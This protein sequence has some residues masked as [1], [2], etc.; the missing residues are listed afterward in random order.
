MK[1]LYYSGLDYSRVKKQFDKTV[2]FL[3]NDDF[4]SAEVKKLSL[5]G[6][7][8]AKID[9][10]NR[11]LFKIA[12]FNNEKYIL[13][14]EVILNH[15]YKK[16][17]FLRGAEIDENKLPEV[18]KSET[19][20]VD[21][22]TS[23][24]FVNQH[25]TKFHLLDKAISFDSNQEEIFNLRP[26]LILIGSAGSGK[27]ALTLEKIK[28]LQGNILYITLSEYLQKNSF[29]LYYYD[30][31]RND[32]QEIDFL[33]YKEFLDTLYI[34][35]KKEMNFKVFDSWLQSRIHSFGFK[36]THKMFEEFRGVLTGMDVN[37]PYLNEAEYQNL[38]VKQAIFLPNE[39]KKVYE[40]FI[41]YLE[42]LEENKYYDINIASYNRLDLSKPYYDFLVIDEVQDFTN[43]QLFIVLKSLKEKGSFIICGDS[44]QIVHP[45]FFSWTKIKSLFYKHDLIGSE[46]KVLRTNYRNSVGITELANLLLKIKNARFGSIDKESTYLI[47]PI[48]GIKGEITLM[49]DNQKTR[50]ILNEKTSRSTKFAV[51]VLNEEEKNSVRNWF[52]TPLLFSIQ[53]AKGLEYE[54]VILYNF[55]SNNEKEYLEI[56]NGVVPNDLI[57]DSYLFSRSKDKSDKSL[58]AYKFYI[59]SLYVA[60]TRGIKNVFIL[61]KNQTHKIL[62]L[63]NLLESKEQVDI[64]VE[65][66]SIDDW[67]KEAYKLELQ[68]KKDQAEDIRKTYLNMQ[69]PDWTPLSPQNILEL[70]EEALNPD[71][72]NK[73]AKDKL[74][75]YSLIYNDL[76]TIKQLSALK[77][78]RADDYQME[79]QGVF[80]KY[81]PEYQSDNVKAIQNNILKWGI[82]YRDQFNLTP[83]LISIQTGSKKILEFLLNN[84]ADTSVTDNYGKNPLRSAIFQAFKSKGYVQ[85]LTFFYNNLVSDNIK[86]KIDNKLIKIDKQKFEYF[87]LNFFISLQA[88]SIEWNKDDFAKLLGMSAGNIKE[89][90]LNYPE[91][92]LPNYRKNQTYISAMLAKN[93]INS[94]NP[95]NRKLFFRT[96]RGCYVLNPALDVFVN[97]TWI[98]VYELTSQNKDQISTEDNRLKNNLIRMKEWVKEMEKNEP[99]IYK[100]IVKTFK[101]TDF[102][103]EKPEGK[104]KPSEECEQLSIPFNF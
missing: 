32:D 87:L 37:K 59:N 23:L 4:R 47:E 93:E 42:Y 67:K 96:I 77:Y 63:L 38:G 48:S 101:N 66:S 2:K 92:M 16:S 91:N 10:E 68:G 64:K 62:N 76:E 7:F 11:L 52:K 79:R 100:N 56:C 50:Q 22:I 31:Y 54:N 65:V 12:D 41:K 55:I 70:K 3:E 82:N 33:H 18:Q 58:D 44:N 15:E 46:L 88:V 61:E 94:S 72:F 71:F 73:K 6:Y 21:D 102:I 39:R 89:N 78:R 97:E 43:I 81:Y 34:N 40:V 45:N 53:E 84:Q 80:R 28:K 83:L 104:K 20:T 98:N 24:N 1:V 19:V 13:L 27:T 5:N 57:D 25:T 90:V 9:Y 30:N 14:L 36:D 95:Y 75:A 86:I 103:E 35:D 26:P 60:V 17:R 69:M 85:N 51:I 99:E 49:G 8:R 74:F 29:N